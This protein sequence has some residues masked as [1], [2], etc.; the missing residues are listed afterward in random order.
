MCIPFLGRTNTSFKIKPIGF[1]YSVKRNREPHVNS[2][3]DN[4][5]Q[6]FMV[7]FGSE[8]LSP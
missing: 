6:K 1:S 5:G 7:K 3:A 4:K 2:L 8:V